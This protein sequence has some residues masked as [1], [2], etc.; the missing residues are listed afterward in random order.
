MHICTAMSAI[1]HIF[2][3]ILWGFSSIPEGNMSHSASLEQSIHQVSK[4]GKSQLAENQTLLIWEVQEDVDD[5]NQDTS[6]TPVR[7]QD[8]KKTYYFFKQTKASKKYLSK[9]IVGP[10]RY[11]RFCNY[12]I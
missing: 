8:S 7:T 10:S 6:W 4:Q 11:T 3:V 5:E 9:I 1:L 12:R 2:F